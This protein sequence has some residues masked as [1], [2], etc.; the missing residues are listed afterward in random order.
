MA[1]MK[2]GKKPKHSSTHGPNTRF[3]SFPNKQHKSNQGTSTHSPNMRI[4]QQGPGR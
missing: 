4:V 3:T 1:N 2:H